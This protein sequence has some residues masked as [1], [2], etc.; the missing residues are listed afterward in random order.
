VDAESYGV[1]T[2]AGFEDLWPRAHPHGPGLTNG[3]NDGVGA[4]DA[5][6]LLVPYPSLTFDKR[7]DLV[8][9]RDHRRMP[10]EVDAAIFGTEAD[11]RTAAGL[12]P[13]DH[14]AVGMVFELPRH[15]FAWR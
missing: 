11:E 1:L 14:A 8:L 13:S 6:G 9:L 15:R 12:W 5:S 7:I 3:P 4:L 2:G 10:R